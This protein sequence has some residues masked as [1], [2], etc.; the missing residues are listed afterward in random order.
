MKSKR[1]DNPTYEP[2]PC[3]D[4]LDRILD[5]ALEKYA[6]AEPRAGLEDRIL[7]TL[8]SAEI[9]VS[10]GAWWHW[11]LAAV[12]AALLVVLAIGLRSTRTREKVADTN[13]PPA[14]TVPAQSESPRVHHDDGAGSHTPIHF[15]ARHHNPAA[16]KNPKLDQFPS[17]HPLS[18]QEQLLARYVAQFNDEAVIVARVRTEATRMD[19]EKE[20]REAEQNGNQDQEAR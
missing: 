14:Q 3:S 8:H 1:M 20:I 19:R 6:S 9:P 11:S 10:H 15:A 17:P 4:E 12:L 5:A 16:P 13:T 18:E 2:A 7:A